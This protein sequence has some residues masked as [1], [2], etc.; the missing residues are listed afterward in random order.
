MPR[1]AQ[2]VLTGPQYPSFLNIQLLDY[3][4]ED[5]DTDWELV[6]KDFLA[7]ASSDDQSPETVL[8]VGFS[9][10]LEFVDPECKVRALAFST[11][12]SVLLV[13]TPEVGFAK[14]A[15]DE[16]RD[17]VRTFLAGTLISGDVQYTLVAL[18]LGSLALALHRDSRL[19]I[20]ALDLSA[21]LD[22]SPGALPVLL[23]IKALNRHEDVRALDHIWSRSSQPLDPDDPEDPNAPLSKAALRAWVT[24]TV[25]H[26]AKIDGPKITAVDTHPTESLTEQVRRSTVSPSGRL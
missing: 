1:V 20:K 5:D 9:L 6:F 15:F 14:A 17:A 7:S 23:V 19:P 10:V 13:K 24:V 26:T 21:P 4:D 25:A 16:R 11:T 18:E 2:T 12:N 3:D 8:P 22:Q